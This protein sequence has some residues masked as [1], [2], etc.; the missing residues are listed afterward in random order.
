[1]AGALK[2][3]F[4]ALQASSYMSGVTLLFG[5]E[6]KRFQ[7]PVLP[8]I[9]MVPVGGPIDDNPGY[10]KGVD[11]AT[12]MI[13]GIHE[14][15]EFWIW[16]NDPSPTAQPIDHADA[17][18]GVRQLLL[19]ALRDQQAQYTDVASVSYGLTWKPTD[20]RWALD[21]DAA[22]R[23]GRALIVSTLP[24]ISVPMASIPGGPEATIT[25]T[26]QTDQFIDEPSG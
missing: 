1:M 12:E 22:I 3:L 17:V 7:E 24:V 15:V 13:W 21:D 11:P 23:W 19:S 20:E 18:E 10:I 25:S 14:R 5:E 2:T 8:A 6:S 9:M 4:G 16:A 26:S